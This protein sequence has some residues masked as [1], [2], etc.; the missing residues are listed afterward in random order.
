MPAI[1]RNCGR[2]DRTRW[3]RSRPWPEASCQKS[4]SAPGPNGAIPV[5]WRAAGSREAS[6]Q[7]S[8]P[9]VTES[10]ESAQ[11]SMAE[12]LR[13]SRREEESAEKTAANWFMPPSVIGGE[14][15]AKSW[16][17][18]GIL[19]HNEKA[20]EE[21]LGSGERHRI[22]PPTIGDC[23]KIQRTDRAAIF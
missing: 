13:E 17:S 7:S 15:I 8:S 14:P 12:P 18:N 11:D 5:T 9:L 23:P 16:E 10:F 6:N 21:C 1:L 20:A 3:L 2:A 4:R 22:V 19:T